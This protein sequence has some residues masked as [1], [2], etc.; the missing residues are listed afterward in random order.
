[1]RLRIS[2]RSSMARRRCSIWPWVMANLPRLSSRTASGALARQA[3]RAGIQV[4]QHQKSW[5]T[6]LQLNH[7]ESWVPALAP[8]A[9]GRDDTRRGSSSEHAEMLAQ[10]DSVARE[11][12]GG[13]HDGD[14]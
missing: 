8:P 14:A 2:S 10:V 3:S 4:P 9:L 13:R 1:M 6:F 11:L 5:S 7:W 12:G